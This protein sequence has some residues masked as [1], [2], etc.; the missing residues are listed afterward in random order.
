MSTNYN[1]NDRVP[2][3]TICTRL[4]ELAH[5]VTLGHEAVTREFTMRIPAELD[6][7]ADIVLSEASRRINE[8]EA[9]LSALLRGEFICHKCSLR[10]DSE[11]DG[12]YDF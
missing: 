4:D 5:A 11:H 12:H 3:E 9:R 8:L 10:K 2:S 6:H 1:H 7:D